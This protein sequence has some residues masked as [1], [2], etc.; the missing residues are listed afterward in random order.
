[1]R[2]ANVAYVRAGPYE[3]DAGGCALV[4]VLLLLLL[5]LLR[6]FLATASAKPFVGRT[7]TVSDVVARTD[8]D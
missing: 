4:R 1:M 3:S 6:A 5:L 2:V 8:T 7:Q